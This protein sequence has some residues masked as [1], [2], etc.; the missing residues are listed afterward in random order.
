M[1]IA[2]LGVDETIWLLAE[3]A[4]ASSQHAVAIVCDAG[5]Y[6]PRFT[7]RDVT[8]VSAAEWEVLLHNPDCAAVAVGRGDHKTTR[9][10]QLRR[11]VQA[12]V[13]LVVTHPITDMLSGFELQMI[14]QDTKS[15]I[16][17]YFPGC[18]HP[19]WQTLVA[20]INDGQQSPV[21]R[22]A[23][24]EWERS[25]ADCSQDR[26]AVAFA[27]DMYVQRRLSGP[28][29]RLGAMTPARGANGGTAD[30]S[31]LSAHMET[32][33][34]VLIRWAV[35]PPT[36]GQSGLRVLGSAAAAQ[37]ELGADPAGWTMQVA[38]SSVALPPWGGPLEILDDVAA[39]ID[40]PSNHALAEEF[41]QA[42]RAVELADTLE[43]SSRRGRTIDLHQEE[44]TEEGTFKSLM[45]AGGCLA[46]LL[47]LGVTLLAALFGPLSPNYGSQQSAGTSS[48]QPWLWLLLL[49]GLLLFLAL[50]L[51]RLLFP[52]SPDSEPESSTS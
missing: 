28:I 16:A 39:A 18:R 21:G 17:P 23:Q 4:L 22:V 9:V 24:F 40:Q 10:E 31:Q 14:Q 34:G 3:A 41:E 7:S 30:W 36:A 52:K 49:A 48:G 8:V 32:A 46:L 12:S 35:R 29:M 44:L 27:R 47:T 51:L 42:C 15:I 25:L 19:I 1:Q 37:V 45:A 11:L 5:D 13:P 33:N 6:A 2:L 43:V 26:I 20:W 50:Q 38:G